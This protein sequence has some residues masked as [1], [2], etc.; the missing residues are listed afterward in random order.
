M[1]ASFI[2]KSSIRVAPSN[3]N[4]PTATFDHLSVKERMKAPC[5]SLLGGKA[6]R[7]FRDRKIHS[8]GGNYVEIVTLA[9]EIHV[10]WIGRVF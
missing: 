9:V 4:R 3:L 1:S 10:F 6:N 7:A 5:A 8:S 2:S